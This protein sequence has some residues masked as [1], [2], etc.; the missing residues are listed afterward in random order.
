MAKINAELASGFKDYLP[1]EMIP[2]QNML[3]KIRAIFE[4]F[5]FYPLETPII[6]KEEVLT[7]GDVNFNKQIFKIAGD[8]GLAL[9]FDLTIPLARVFAANSN[10]SRPFKRYQIG[11]AFRAEHAQLGRFREFTQCDAD[12]VGSD[13]Q[14]ADA[15]I[16]SL[17]YEALSSL[18]LRDFTIKIGSRKILSGIVGESAPKNSDIEAIIRIIDKLDKIGWAG[19]EK[20]LESLNIDL[21]IEELKKDLEADIMTGSI[22]AKYPNSLVLKDGVDELLGV[23]D[24]LEALSVPRENFKVDLSI[25]RGLGYYTGIVF[26]TILKDI[27]NIGSIASGGR[28]DDLVSRFSKDK[29]PAVGVSI[30]VDR[31]FTALMKLGSIKLAKKM[32]DVLILNFDGSSAEKVQKTATLLR[33]VNIKTEIYLG[34]D[35]SFKGQLAY[36]VKEEFPILVIIGPKEMASGSIQI[37]D[38]INREQFEVPEAGLLAKIQE[39]LAKK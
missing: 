1:E 3:D 34:S 19:I 30:G 2:K 10:I 23:L 28:Y 16:I 5:G 20:E 17:L 4:R 9:R 37:K 25:A 14:M 39:L 13:S 32:A 11:K 36:A 24:H 35:N 8:S 27:P 22:T 6:E 29:V 18:G 21:K 33:S 26:E 7:G 12:I 38:M 15:E 31:L